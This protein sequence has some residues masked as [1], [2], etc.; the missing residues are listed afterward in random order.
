MKNIL[1]TGSAGFIGSNFVIHVIE[2]NLAEKIVSLDKLTYAG[3][4][5]NLKK[6][7]NSSN[8]IFIKG[9]IGDSVLVRELLNEYQIDTIINF[10]AESHVDR[11]IENPLAFVETNVLG[12]ARLLHECHLYY[13]K[14]PKK[15]FKFHHI[16]TD[17]VY[18]SLNDN[19]P[20]FTEVT[21]F[22][23]NSPYSASKASSDHFARAYHHTYGLP[24]TISNCSNNYG[25]R[26]HPE[27]LIP[28][29]IRCCFENKPIPIYGNGKNIR[30]WLFVQDHVEGIIQILQHGKSGE[31][32]NIGGEQ[33]LDNLSL[34]KMI[35][36]LMDSYFIK[37][38]I[39]KEFSCENLLQFV[40][41][42]PGHDFRYS[43]DISK[44][45]KEFQWSPHK[46]THEGLM[47]TIEYYAHF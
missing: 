26:Q 40:H 27:K 30:D 38:N 7:Q 8:H 37:N 9:D 14:N 13:Q 34:A 16:S 18:G 35:C 25:P 29:I 6:I 4:L 41:D 12:T 28:T 43:V 15:N 2:N 45:K 47:E 1:V 10:A 11:S 3:N 21:P 22:A 39:K 33:E 44:M 36:E 20:S 23:P 19:D 5:E 24:L 46:K 32:Y 17:E 31:T 42:R